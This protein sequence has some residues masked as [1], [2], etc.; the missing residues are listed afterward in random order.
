MN[1][2][3]GGKLVCA[4]P[5]QGI[6]SPDHKQQQQQGMDDFSESSWHK[7]EDFRVWRR[8]LAESGGFRRLPKRARLGP[9][10]E[11]PQRGKSRFVTCLTRPCETPQVR[12][13]SGSCQ[14]SPQPGSNILFRSWWKQQVLTFPGGTGQT[15]KW[16]AAW[17]AR[18][19]KW[20]CLKAR[21][22]LL[23]IAVLK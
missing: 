18:H 21:S 1:L 17:L 23:L 7:K 13:R 19:R 20:R 14:N 8:F 12:R 4:R 6:R 5:G 11:R 16:L 10:D 9:W 22:R 3:T 2:R 15:W